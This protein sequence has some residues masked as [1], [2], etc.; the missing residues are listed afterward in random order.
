MK[1]YTILA[2]LLAV[3]LVGCGDEE[4][5]MPTT[6]ITCDTEDITYT[7]T[8]ASLING[9]CAISGCHVAN[10][11]TFPIENYDQALAAADMG[12]MVGALNR[13]SGFSQMPRGAAKLDQCVIDQ[14]EA[15]IEDGAPE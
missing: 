6:I 10:T 1:L 13:E 8:V 5:E 11:S 14:V 2:C 3:M 4:G 9:S 15:W 12:R 7:N